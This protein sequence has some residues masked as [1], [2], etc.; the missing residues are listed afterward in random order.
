MKKIKITLML[1][2][3]AL[4]IWSGICLLLISSKTHSKSSSDYG[5]ILVLGSKIEGNNL[6]DSYPAAA[7]K[8][9]L[10]AAVKLAKARPGSRVIVSGGKG[11]DEPVTEA[12]AMAK[13]LKAKGIPA[14]QIIEEDKASD[15]SE[16]LKFSKPYLKGK[17]VLVTNDFHLYRS[18]YLAKKQGLDKLEGEAVVSQTKNPLLW[19]GYYG[20]EILGL[21]YAFIF[22][23]G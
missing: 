16:N 9:R 5:S 20:H 3:G 21:T 8:A 22:G 12:S 17:T 10:D 19:T 14:S 23:E 7:T 13:Y 1:L 11:F 18:L 15:T 4:I 6:A 2:L